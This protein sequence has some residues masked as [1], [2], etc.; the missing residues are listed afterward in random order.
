MSHVLTVVTAVT[1]NEKISLQNFVT[2]CS[3][4]I[5]AVSKKQQKIVLA[6]FPYRISL[7]NFLTWNFLTEFPYRM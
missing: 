1:E 3:S 7:Q 4:R 2:D 6:E 5:T